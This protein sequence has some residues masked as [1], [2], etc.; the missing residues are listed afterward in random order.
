MEGLTKEQQFTQ[1]EDLKCSP[2][3]KENGQVFHKLKHLP[4][5][6]QAQVFWMIQNARGGKNETRKVN[7]ARITRG[8]LCLTRISHII[9]SM[10][11]YK[12]KH[13]KEARQIK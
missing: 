7:W 10:N 2:G 13:P 4:E 9:I 11:G 12:L 8:T 1:L 5:L 3:I 6:D